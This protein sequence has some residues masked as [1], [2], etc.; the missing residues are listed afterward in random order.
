MN[1]GGVMTFTFDKVPNG[2][3][4]GTSLFEDEAAKT[5]PDIKVKAT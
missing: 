1:I 4:I 5:V 2:T 3:Q